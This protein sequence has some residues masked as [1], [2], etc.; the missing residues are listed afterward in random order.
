MF[1]QEQGSNLH[2]IAY[3][4]RTLMP[5]EKNYYLHSSKLEF[6]TLKWAICDTFMDYLYFA[7]TFT[8]YTD[9]NPLTYVLSTAKVNAVGHCCVGELA[10]FHLTI[11]YRPEKV[12]IDADILSRYP[13]TLHYHIREY[14]EVM[15]RYVV[16]AIWPGDKA[17]K[18]NDVPW[19]AALQLCASDSSPSTST[20]MFTPDDIRSTQGGDMSICEVMT[21]K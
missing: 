7:P 16:S 5:A 13:M 15:P 1:Y 8:I 10:D 19:L 17:M 3:G 6:L 11:K 20:T 18:D 4:S 14:T 12:N 2:F 9:N 21:L